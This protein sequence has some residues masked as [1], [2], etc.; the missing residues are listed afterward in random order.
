MPF[1]A[2]PL[3]HAMTG[4]HAQKLSRMLRE[5]KASSQP[6]ACITFR[7]TFMPWDSSCV[8]AVM[9]FRRQS[10]THLA[11]QHWLRHAST[12]HHTKMPRCMFSLNITGGWP[13]WHLATALQRMTQLLTCKGTW[14]PVV[15]TAGS[16]RIGTAFQP[17]IS[18][19]IGPTWSH[20]VCLDVGS[21]MTM[22]VPGAGCR[23]PG[24][25]S[26]GI[27]WVPESSLSI[28]WASIQR[29]FCR[30]IWRATNPGTGLMFDWTP[31]AD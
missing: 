28:S 27:S 15:I 24:A 20:P 11:G 4:W 5:Q 3:W 7:W 25:A 23:V 12:V 14:S 22:V 8:L 29:R 9:I 30:R 1:Y 31:F 13:L 19:P 10:Q 16:N 21:R 6:A 18:F 2:H 17:Q 26:W